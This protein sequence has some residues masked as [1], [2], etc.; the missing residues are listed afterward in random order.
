GRKTSAVAK[1][2]RKAEA[3]EGAGK[4]SGRTRKYLERQTA[5]VRAATHILNRKGLRGMTL[6][7]VADR[8]GLV[9]TGVAYY[10]RSKEALAAACFHKSIDGHRR[11]ITAASE[12]PTFEERLAA[13]VRGHFDH[14]RRVALGDGEELA[15]FED[16]RSLGDPTVEAA[17]VEMFRDVRRLFGPELRLRLGRAALNTRTHLLIQQLVWAKYWLENY[18]PDDYSRA[19]ERVLDILLNGMATEPPAWPPASLSLHTPARSSEETATEMFLRAATQLINEQGYPGASVERITARLDVTKGSFYHHIDAK[20]DLIEICYL[21]TL[22]VM[23]RTQRAASFLPLD[24]RS[25]LAS[26]LAHLIDRQL[27][28]QA[29]LLRIVTTSVPEAIQTRI[30][31]DSVRI[32][33]H[34]GATVSD[35]VADASLRPIDAHIAS[36][37]LTSASIA[38][39]ELKNWLPGPPDGQTTEHFIRP[40]F[41]GLA[42]G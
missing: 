9:P 7:E 1:P 4:A 27:D 39:A 32:G 16:I 18:E 6:A 25:R 3:P 30:R 21:R 35:G 17:Y 37:M 33:V 2:R 29:P 5:I 24:A 11:L 28:G 15:L 23:H 12:R 26:T 36:Q 34:F 19:A 38:G 40:L 14:L 8:F 20:A 41:E 13:L 10:F 22:E 31:L 42:A